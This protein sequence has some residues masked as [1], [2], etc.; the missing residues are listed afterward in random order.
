MPVMII[1]QKTNVKIIKI[2]FFLNVKGL[3]PS[4][5]GGWGG[6]SESFVLKA[7]YSTFHM[8]LSPMV[9][10]SFLC[11]GSE[12]KQLQLGMLVFSQ[13]LEPDLIKTHFLSYTHSH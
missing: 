7:F 10:V 9:C 13:F 12:N 11:V 3:N 4:P 1:E 8:Y 2:F 5:P 6:V